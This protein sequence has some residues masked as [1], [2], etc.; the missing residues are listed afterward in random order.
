MRW[1]SPYERAANCTSGPADGARHLLAWLIEEYPLGWSGGIFNCRN[2]RGGVT[3]STHGEGR[4]VDFMLPVV[5]G[6]GHPTGHAIVRRLGT[7]G[8]RLGFQF[9]IF[10]RR[11]WSAKNPG[12][13]YYGGT[14]PHRDHLHIELTWAAARNLTLATLRSVLGEEDDVKPEDIQAI[15]DGVAAKVAA[16]GLDPRTKE[17]IAKRVWD[18]DIHGT[19]EQPRPARNQLHDAR[20]L[21]AQT[22]RAIEKHDEFNVPPESEV[23]A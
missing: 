2:V 11:Q 9:V 22:K 4:A 8:D 23:D 1:A 15:I 20:V 10:D 5:N 17:D 21:S 13:G 18:H 7:T 19:E 12:G 3:K 14:H 16:Q 6:I